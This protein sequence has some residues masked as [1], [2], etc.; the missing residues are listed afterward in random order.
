MQHH[1]LSAQIGELDGLTLGGLQGE[2]VK[3]FAN[4][5][6][7]AGPGR[8]IGGE[9]RAP[10]LLPQG[11]IE[12]HCLVDGIDLAGLPGLGLTVGQGLLLGQAG[13]AGLGRVAPGP[14]GGDSEGA[15]RQGGEE[16]AIASPPAFVKV[17]DGIAIRQAGGMARSAEGEKSGR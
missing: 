16:L 3:A 8:F 17:G 15:G 14:A 5:D 11:L 4:R 7:D 12:Y 2:V 13:A 6:A 1:H 9:V 10:G